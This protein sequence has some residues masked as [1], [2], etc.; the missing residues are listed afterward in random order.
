MLSGA[1]QAFPN[2]PIRIV[3]GETGGGL[4]LAARLISP[5]MLENTGQPVVVQNR[6][7]ATAPLLV[8]KAR[9]DGYTLLLYGTPFW[10]APFMRDDVAYDPVKDFAPITLVSTAPT[11]LV[12]HPSVAAGFVKEL[13]A[14]AKAKPG[15]LN[16]AASSAGSPSHLAGELFKAMAG[17]NIVAVPYKGA[18]PAMVALFS[19]EVQLTFAAAAS[20]T[21]HLKSGRLKVL[22][23]TSAQP[24]GLFPGVPTVASSGFPG[25]QAGAL[26]G[27]FAPVETPP[28]IISR[29]N[30]EIVSVLARADVRE[31]FV[32]GGAEAVGS[33]ARQFEIEMKTDMAVSGK[34]IKDA[35]IRGE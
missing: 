35:G 12:V 18:G 20:V 10:L 17:V 8:S 24:S 28:A 23:V 6:G 30:K 13:I 31:K 25:F 14:L 33:T 19:N 1:G 34:V 15:Q 11:A 3:T 2:K 7:L 4:D 29:L 21:P 27:M 26:I 5:V 22:A 9:P 16:Y 32:N